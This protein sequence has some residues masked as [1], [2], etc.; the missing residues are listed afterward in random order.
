M[1]PTPLDHLLFVVLVLVIPIE[2]AFEFREFGAAIRRNQPRARSLILIRTIVMQW[3]LV[4]AL[5][6]GWA[7]GQRSLDLLGLHWTVGVRDIIGVLGLGLAL[8]FVTLQ[9]RSIRALNAD[10][11]ATLIERSG[12]TLLLLP[13]NAVERRLFTATSF[14][15]GFCEELLN[16][17]F[18]FW[19]LA[20]WLPS[21]SIVPASSALFGCMHAYQGV[22]GAVR[23]AVVGAF[24]GGLY[25]GT[26]TL[27]WPVLAHAAIDL[28][29]GAVGRLLAPEVGTTDVVNT[30]AQGR[31]IAT[32]AAAS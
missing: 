19:Y 2:G 6:A 26:D 5:L 23:T 1:T 30:M 13:T 15:A 20:L 7:S 10:Q 8:V 3:A 12:D 17:G 28:G 27:L 11:R 18:L 4:S 31:G 21:W 25:V 29:A 9:Y 22:Q 32:D 14:T 24:L 16:R